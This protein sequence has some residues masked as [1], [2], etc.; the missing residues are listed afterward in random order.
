MS[1]L[2]PNTPPVLNSFQ[3]LD[4]STCPKTADVF[5]KDRNIHVYV[6]D[7]QW[8]VLWADATVFDVL[9][10]FRN[11]NRWNSCTLT[12]SPPSNVASPMAAPEDPNAPYD[13]TVRFLN[14]GDWVDMGNGERMEC[15]GFD[16]MPIRMTEMHEIM[17]LK[18]RAIHG[19]V[20]V[21]HC[22]TN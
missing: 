18:S 2:L 9:C 6:N 11:E 5:V 16:I 10:A 8:F 12:L 17:K 1:D 14:P 13:D 19:G 3:I 7:G 20:F 15:D 4:D 21:I 22:K